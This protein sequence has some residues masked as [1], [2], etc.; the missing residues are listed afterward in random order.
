MSQIQVDA[1]FCA[2]K[3][4][5]GERASRGEE[6]QNNFKGIVSSPQT[7]KV[8]HLSLPCMVTKGLFS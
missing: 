8:F 4:M 1:I 2:W 6:M 5:E 7:S 3:L